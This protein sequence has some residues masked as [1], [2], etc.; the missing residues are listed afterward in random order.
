MKTMTH[1]DR[2]RALLAQAHLGAKQ[3]GLDEDARHAVQAQVTGCG[4]CRDMSEA[5]LAAL[6]RHYAALGADVRA[7]AP[8][9][10]SAEGATRWQLATLERLSF[11][12]GWSGGLDDPQLLAFVR[13]TAQ[14]ERCEWLSRSACSAVISGLQ[15]WMR[16]KGAR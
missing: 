9:A 13:R 11:D 8:R 15:R 7:S 6:I 14:V 5:Q 16:Q 12:F 1:D 3:L 2:R 10:A 4:S